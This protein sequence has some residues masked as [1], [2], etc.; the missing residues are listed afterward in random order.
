MG[1]RDDLLVTLNLSEAKNHGSRP[2]PRGSVRRA[3]GFVLTGNSSPNLVREGLPNTGQ[4]NESPSAKPPPEVFW[5]VRSCILFQLDFPL[6]VEKDRFR[7]TRSSSD[8]RR[9]TSLRLSRA[10]RDEY[11]TRNGVRP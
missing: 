5:R 4:F 10:S 2:H 8:I 11:S 9:V 3:I 1:H 6:Q 7:A